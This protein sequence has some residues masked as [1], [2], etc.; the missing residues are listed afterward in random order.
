MRLDFST[1]IQLNPASFRQSTDCAMP[2][3]AEAA[4]ISA[5]FRDLADEQTG[6][7]ETTAVCYGG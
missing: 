4:G 7:H 3:Q 1:D 5:A 2:L 6:S